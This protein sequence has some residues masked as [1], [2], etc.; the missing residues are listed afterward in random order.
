MILAT[1]RILKFVTMEL[2]MPRTINLTKL[3]ANFK[4]S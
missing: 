4:K 3:L 2:I 1:M